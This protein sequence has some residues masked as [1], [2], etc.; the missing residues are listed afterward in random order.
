MPADPSLPLMLPGVR[1]PARKRRLTCRAS[2][3]HAA[4]AQPY[5]YGC[6]R[7]AQAPRR[8]SR[9]CT[10]GPCGWMSTGASGARARCPALG[11][12]SMPAGPMRCEHREACLSLLLCCSRMAHHVSD[13]ACCSPLTLLGA[14]HGCSGPW[15]AGAC[16]MLGNCGPKGPRGLL[17]GGRGCA[18]GSWVWC[19]GAARSTPWCLPAADRA[20]CAPVPMLAQAC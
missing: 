2:G 18:R 9:C 1:L 7:A 14:R 3:R 6:A 4:H 20:L 8:S 15:A 13:N 12:A 10:P 16:E 17:L 5:L 19:A 11:P